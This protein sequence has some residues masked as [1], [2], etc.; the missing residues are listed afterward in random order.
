MKSIGEY[1]LR[2]TDERFE[3][4]TAPDGS[5][6]APNSELTYGRLIDSKGKGVLRKD[7]RINDKGAAVAINK[8][9][10]IASGMLRANIT[11][12]LEDGGHTLIIGSNEP[13]AAVQ[14]FGAAQGEFGRNS[15]N[16]PIPWGNIPARPFMGISTGDET[17]ILDILNSELQDNS[18]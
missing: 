2:A 13:Y 18:P 8:K 1:M 9:P 11:Y 7:G 3:S 16:A 15:R 10:L 5:R 6:W 4:S 14:Q 17:G 12:Q